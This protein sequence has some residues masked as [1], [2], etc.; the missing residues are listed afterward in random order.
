MR[1]GIL[2]LVCMFVSWRVELWGEAASA[3][4]LAVSDAESRHEGKL[5]LAMSLS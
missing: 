1:S 4:H 5:A 3:E 2:S